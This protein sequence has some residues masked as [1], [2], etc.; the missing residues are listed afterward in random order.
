MKKSGRLKTFVIQD[1][2]IEESGLAYQVNEKE[3]L[4][5]LDSLRK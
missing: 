3:L 2:T 5:V 1:P 4:V